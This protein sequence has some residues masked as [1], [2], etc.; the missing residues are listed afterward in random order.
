MRQEHSQSA[1]RPLIYSAT[2]ALHCITYQA[3][4][5]ING[6]KSDLPSLQRMQTAQ[7]NINRMSHAKTLRISSTHTKAFKQKDLCNET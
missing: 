4:L 3:R 1:L 2:N 6:G 5:K 7:G